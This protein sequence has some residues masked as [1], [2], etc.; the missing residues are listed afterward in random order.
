LTRARLRPALGLVLLLL[1][2]LAS[3]PVQAAP[4]AAILPSIALRPDCGPV[5]SGPPTPPVIPQAVTATPPPTYAIEVIGRGLAPGEADVIFNPGSAQ[6]SFAGTI[7]SSGAEDDV[8]H[9]ITVPAG[10]YTVEVR[11]FGVSEGPPPP[12]AKAVFVVP[13]PQPPPPPPVTPTVGVS[14]TRGGP[15]PAVLDPKLTLSPAVG[16][17]GT[18]TL[19][20]GADFPANVGIQLSWSQGIAASPSSAIVTDASGSFTA[21]VLVFPHDELGTRVL[22]AVSV[23][24][25]GSSQFGFASAAFLVV[26]GEV[27]P[28]DF[29]WRR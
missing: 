11:P 24:P 10:T 21:Q 13:C 6:Q 29:S 5:G 9:P 26:P 3:A 16:P 17:P 4:A 23:V 18:V 28:R 2:T 14:P 1:G 7:D 25:P 20:H 12:G 8:I 27:Q 19:A 22:T 15:T